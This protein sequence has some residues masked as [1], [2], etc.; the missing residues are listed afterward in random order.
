MKGIRYLDQACRASIM[1]ND[2]F[3]EG[4]SSLFLETD[5]GALT[6]I[7]MNNNNNNIRH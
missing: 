2:K 5:Y 1:N 3:I 4:G 6:V 7:N